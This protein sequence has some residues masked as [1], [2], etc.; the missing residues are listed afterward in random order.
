MEKAAT[1]RRRVN[2]SGCKAKYIS[3]ATNS[4][5]LVICT[6]ENFHQSSAFLANYSRRLRKRTLLD[7]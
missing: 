6:I 2:A 5:C 1:N 7:A 4:G 3:N